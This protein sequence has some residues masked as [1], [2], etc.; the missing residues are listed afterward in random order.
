M[1]ATSGPGMSLMLEGIGY[2]SVTET[3]SV[4]INVMRGG[5]STG[6]PTLSA[7]QDVYQAKYGSH[8]DYEVVVLAPSSVQEAFD[9]TL[10]AFDIAEQLL[11]PVIILSDEIVGHT[12]ERVV[13]PEGHKPYPRR[14]P[15]AGEEYVPFRP[16]ERG[17]PKR[18]NFGEGHNIL[19][20]GQLHD[21]YGTRIGHLTKPSAALVTRLCEKITK[22]TDIFED[23]EIRECDDADLILVTYG[24]TSRPALRAMKEARDQGLKVGWV[25]I[26]TLFPFPDK[27]LEKLV[28]PGRKFMV[29]EMNIGKIVNE[30]TRVTGTKAI[31]LS[32]MGGEM[33]TPAEVLEAIREVI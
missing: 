30:V 27:T 6:Q 14:K 28:K 15:E 12:R 17:V 24:S 33:H 25:K 26:R 11:T 18:A 23:V 19:V 3:P 16:D 22:N 7:Q 31:S 20:D 8:G 32:K 9:M 4:I 1:T 29:P 13:I 2:A 5:P 21:E 10:K